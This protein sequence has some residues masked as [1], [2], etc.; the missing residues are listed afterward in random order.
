MRKERSEIIRKYEF[1]KIL[2]QEKLRKEEYE[3]RRQ[4]NIE[5]LKQRTLTTA[6]KR[7]TRQNCIK[8]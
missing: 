1:K 8:I 7:R 6:F 5:Q 3:R 4:L 2:E